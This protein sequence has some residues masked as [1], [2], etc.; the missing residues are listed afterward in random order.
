[1]FA[2]GGSYAGCDP[3]PP[4]LWGAQT[5]LRIVYD[6]VGHGKQIEGGRRYSNRQHGGAEGKRGRKER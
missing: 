5:P 2:S 4:P 6:P 3:P 1:M